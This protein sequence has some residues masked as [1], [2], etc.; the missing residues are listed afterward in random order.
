MELRSP[1]AISIALLLLA[2][3]FVAWQFADGGIV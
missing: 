2:V 1:K 3:A